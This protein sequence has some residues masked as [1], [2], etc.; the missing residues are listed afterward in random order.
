MDASRSSSDDRPHVLIAEDEA[1][2]SRLLEDML[3]REPVRVTTVHTGSDALEQIR[4]DRSISLVLLDLVMPGM[5][6]LEVLEAARSHRSVTDLPILVL[7]GKGETHL[8]ERA[9]AL[10][11]T[12]F[13]TKPFSPRSLVT[14]IREHCLP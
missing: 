7:T 8:R 1:H 6:G 13:L 11:A 12:E 9:V 14:R 2:L 10:G 3:A 5:D 4:S